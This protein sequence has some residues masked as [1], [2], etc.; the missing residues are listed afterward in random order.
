MTRHLFQVSNEALQSV[1]VRD[2]M[3]TYADMIEMRISDPPY[4]EFD[5]AVPTDDGTLKL[6]FAPVEDHPDT[7]E[8]FNRRLGKNCVIL[9]CI[10]TWLTVNNGRPRTWRDAEKTTAAANEDEKFN[11]LL[12]DCTAIYVVFIV[13]LATRNV[14]KNTVHNSLAKFGVG[15]AKADYVTTLSLG[16]ITE[17]DYESGAPSGRTMR[18]HMRRGHIRRQKHGPGFTFERK[19]FIQ[20][21]MVNSDREPVPG[22]RVAYNVGGLHG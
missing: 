18:P 8:I 3:A 9:D 15:K 1:G 21:V 19:I 14:V 7:L 5:L 10:S 22:D 13:L 11:S 20:P 2:A 4:P 6:H 16:D 17:N 12:R